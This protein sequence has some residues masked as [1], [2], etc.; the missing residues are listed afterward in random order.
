MLSPRLS[1]LRGE[2]AT[3]RGWRRRRRCRRFRHHP[4]NAPGCGPLDRFVVDT[5]ITLIRRFVQP[6]GL[7]VVKDVLLHMHAQPIDRSPTVRLIAHRN[8]VCI[9][10][11]LQ[12]RN[13]GS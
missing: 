7:H 1:T 11:R 5:E 4:R 12:R 6:N 2:S 13:G 3:I 8:G 9:S 10:G